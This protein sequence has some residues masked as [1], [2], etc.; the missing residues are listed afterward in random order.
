MGASA[1]RAGVR[2]LN[3]GGIPTA[4]TPN[5]AVDALLNLVRYR[6]T[7]D[8]AYET[9]REVP[10]K[11]DVDRRELRQRLD[12]LFRSQREILFE[13]EAKSILAA[14]GI[15]VSE[16]R[17][18]HTPEEVAAIASQMGFPVVL[19]VVSPQVVH[20]TEVGGVALNLTNEADVLTAYRAMLASVK[21]KCPDAEIRAISVQPMVTMPGGIELI[22]GLKKDPIFGPVIMIGLGGIAAELFQDRALGLP[23]LNERLA[24]HMLESLRTWPLIKGYRGRQAIADVDRLIEI[25]L[26]FSALASDCPQIRELDANPIVVRGRE[27]IV[28]DARVVVDQAAVGHPD[29]RPYCHLAIA[30]YPE[31]LVE[32]AA[33]SDGTPITLRPIRPEDEPLWRQL[34]ASCSQDSLWARFRFGFKTD[35]HEAAIRFCFVD[36][37]RELTVAA[38]ANLAGGRRLI[39]VARLTSDVGQPRAEFAILVGDAWQGKGLGTLLTQYCLK[40][41]HR[42][43]IAEIYATTGRDNVRMIRVFQ[44]LGFQVSPSTDATLVRATRAVS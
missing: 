28:L 25:L 2:I 31:D 17:E 3:D 18:G 19:K 34:L 36:Y 9:P 1:V 6:R 33:L 20:K 26:R 37:D 44:N 43:G 8:I 27:A 15:P 4:N 21:E 29:A 11:F 42:I 24:M 32:A 35:T 41:S 7:L 12:K 13:A 16:P 23:P 30:P 40:H 39:G 22:I 10:L 5:D 38:E 14:Y